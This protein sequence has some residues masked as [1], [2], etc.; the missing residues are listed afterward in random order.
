MHL[1]LKRTPASDATRWE[2]W[3]AALTKWRL[4]SDYSHGGIVIDG[5]LYHSSARQG[6]LGWEPFDMAQASVGW[7]FIDLGNERDGLAQSLFLRLHGT[8]YN[9]VGLLGFVVPWHI[10]TDRL[11]C[12][13]WCALAM[14]IPVTARITPER[15][16]A[17]ATTTRHRRVFLRPEES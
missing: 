17:A 5:R 1:A 11:Y 14:G 16:L 15:L 12:F 7:D 13:E 8:P 2:R 10:E 9:Y 4:V 3:F 6:G